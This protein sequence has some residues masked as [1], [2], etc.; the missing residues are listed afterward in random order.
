[1]K[2]PHMNTTSSNKWTLYMFWPITYRSVSLDGSKYTESYVKSVVKSLLTYWQVISE[3]LNSQ[4]SVYLSFNNSTP[5]R[6]WTRWRYQMETFSALLALCAR[7][8]RR[9]FLTNASDAELLMFSLSC[10]WIIGWV[11]NREDGDLRC[12]LAHYDVIVTTE[13]VPTM[14]QFTL[15]KNITKGSIKKMNFQNFT[16]QAKGQGK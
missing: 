7:N 13:V 8:H 2:L 14:I 10:A 11:N 5:Q 15:T 4:E 3:E 9:I 16:C 12:H 6:V 1:M